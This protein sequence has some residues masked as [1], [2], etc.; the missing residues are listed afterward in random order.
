M[1]EVIVCIFP[2]YPRGELY[3]LI[4]KVDSINSKGN[5]AHHVNCGKQHEA[6][7]SAHGHG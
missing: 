4:A 2:R 1:G 3:P 7:V 6:Q 5:S